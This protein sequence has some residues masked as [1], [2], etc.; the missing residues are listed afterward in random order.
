M[1]FIIPWLVKPCFF[2][3]QFCDIIKSVGDNMARKKTSDDNG[4]LFLFI[5]AI[6]IIYTIIKQNWSEIRVGLLIIG[7]LLLALFITWIVLKVIK[8]RKHKKAYLASYFYQETLLPYPGR[9]QNRGLEFEMDVYNQIRHA[10]GP[11]FPMLFDVM[12]PKA[13]AFYMDSQIDLIVFHTSGIYVLELKN[14]SGPLIGRLEDEDWIPYIAVRKKV[15]SNR[16]EDCYQP[17][18]ALLNKSTK[19]WIYNP[20]KQNEGHIDTLKSIMPATYDNI[21]IFS[22]SMLISGK[23]YNLSQLHSLSSF[24]ESITTAPER[25]DSSQLQQIYQKIKTANSQDSQSKLLHSARLS[26]KK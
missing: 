25:F 10:I 16:F 8:H 19:R 5:F 3:Y 15:K 12:V 13:N 21:I 11:Q 14:F 23:P 17:N 24:I 9:K 2:C 22:D 4:G 20:I 1:L 6:A 26:R 18:F 7:S